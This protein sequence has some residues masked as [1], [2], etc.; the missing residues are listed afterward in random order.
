MESLGLIRIVVLLIAIVFFYIFS[1][2]LSKRRLQGYGLFGLG[3]ALIMI[4]LLLGSLF[5][6]S[7]LSEAMKTFLV[8]KLGFMI[9][10]IGQTLGLFLLLA[11]TYRL[12]RS[13][14][15]HLDAHY[16]SLVEN[17]SVGVYLIQDGKFVFVNPR[18][19]EVSGYERE[20]LIG[21]SVLEIV[22]SSHR[23]MV[24]E[25]LRKGI[26]GEIN[27][28]NYECQGLTKAGKEIDVEV[29]GSRTI[30]NGKPAL[31]GTL[32]PIGERKRT[33]EALRVSEERFRMLANSGYEVISE[34][35]SAGRYLYLSPSVKEILGYRQDDLAGQRVL[36]FIHPDDRKDV[37][38]EFKKSIHEMGS[39]RALF[40]VK[41]KSG[42]WLWVES[43]G[44]AYRTETGEIRTIIVNHDITERKQLEEELAKTSKIESLG[45]L[46]GGI[47]HDFNNILTVILGNVSVVK[48]DP[49]L[50]ER[51]V[52]TLSEAEAACLQARE[53]TQQLLTFSKGGAPIKK[54]IS[55]AQL[56]KDTIQ[57]TLRGSN[58]KCEL[59]IQEDLW[60]VDIDSGQ[61]SQVI[62]NLIINAD[63]AMPDGGT[64][65]VHAEN[66][67]LESENGVPLRNGSYVRISFEDKGVGIQEEYLSKIFDPYFTTKQRGSGLGLA[68]CYSIIKKHEGHITVESVLGTGTTFSIYLP[69]SPIRFKEHEVRI[70]SSRNENPLDKHGRVLV[71]D[72]EEAI[73]KSVGR[74]LKRMGYEVELAV[75]GTE[76]IERYRKAHEAGVP[77][78]AVVMDLTIR[79]G[80]GGREAVQRLLE[81]DSDI[82]AIVSSGYS[83]D[84]VMADFRKY[85]FKGVVAKP[86]QIEKLNQVLQSVVFEEMV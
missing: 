61:M 65:K 30:Y 72:D 40:R 42:A 9:G 12:V 53:L 69:A 47:A 82:R 66:Q 78:D 84:P 62:N 28:I 70:K 75:D 13:L 38:S 16:S 2:R 50:S 46:A 5:H 55:I 10:Y 76:A 80:M 54:T 85:G 36:D 81:I 7:L 60:P 24:A 79:G 18:F 43:T 26:Q 25:N 3:F 59:E 52:T 56:I 57:F 63:Q 6:S 1:R 41:H 20:E 31:H 83:N 67:T 23:N 64:I 73:R 17:A 15:P 22:A 11:G 35:S 19:A 8:P 68:T 45:V 29:Y 51:Q 27:S 86:Y 71:M 77:F 74:M 44:Q 58:V 4:D 39:W 21:K 14:Q 33:Q 49:G 37:W 48:S 34:V 32:L